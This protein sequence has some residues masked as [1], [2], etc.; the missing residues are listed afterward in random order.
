MINRLVYGKRRQDRWWRFD[1]LKVAFCQAQL[2]GSSMLE[3]RALS[4]AFQRMGYGKVPADIMSLWHESVGIGA[5]R[6]R[7][8]RKTD[9]GRIEKISLAIDPLSLPYL[10]W[11]DLYR[12]FLGIG[13]YSPAEIMR[14]QALAKAKAATKAPAGESVEQLC[15]GFYARVEAQNFDSAEALLN[16]M[17]RKG[18][19]E[20]RLEQAQWFCSLLSGKSETNCIKYNGSADLVNLEFANF[21]EGKQVA[22]VGPVASS[23]DQGAE[24]DSYDVV[25]K[26]SYRGGEKGKDPKTQGRRLDVSYYNNV[27]ANALAE[28]G[29]DTVLSALCWGVCINRKGRSC[30]PKNQPNVRQLASLEWMLPDTHFNA[31]P[32]AVLD[33]LRFNPAEIRV[34]NTDLMLSAGRFAGYNPA[35]AKPIDYTRSFI[36]THD[37]ILQYKVMQR[38]WKIGLIS[39]D[40][41]FDEVMV[42]GVQKY[43]EQLQNAHG[44]NERLLF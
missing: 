11:L 42:L 38:L 35:G 12:L 41:R 16:E 4:T 20:S 28:A 25:V 23:T 8:L 36:K 18:C 1:T 14:S 33:L 2:A 37:P 30:F 24:I 5:A 6:L 3:A 10:C 32:N 40:A 34:F 17:R 39:G 43:M 22:L 44:A 13:L 29:L 27:Q 21:I 15:A 19:S 7:V 9:V 26:F 31:G